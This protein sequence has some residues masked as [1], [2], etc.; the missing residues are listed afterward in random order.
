MLLAPAF[1][2]A[3]VIFACTDARQAEGRKLPA[4]IALRDYNRN[5]PLR[6]LAGVFETFNI[7]WRL[8]P[9]VIV[10]TGAAPG[11]LCLLWGRLF[12]ARTIWIDSIANS[13]ELSMSGKLARKFC[14]RVLTQWQHL[15]RADGNPSYWGS[16]L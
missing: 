2:G 16:V 5:Q 14:H 3:D 4:F 7:V 1:D 10:S 13:E 9:D 15:E 11:L 6:T 8:R 12:S